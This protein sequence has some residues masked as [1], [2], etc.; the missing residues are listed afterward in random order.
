MVDIHA[1]SALERFKI[2][3]SRHLKNPRYDGLSSDPPVRFKSRSN[4]VFESG[5]DADRARKRGFDCSGEFFEFLGFSREEIFFEIIGKACIE[6][7]LYSEFFGSFSIEISFFEEIFLLPFFSSASE[8]HANF[9][10]V[11]V[12]KNFLCDECCPHFFDL[13]REEGDFFF[14]EEQ[15]AFAFRIEFFVGVVFIFGDVE[16]DDD[17]SPVVDRDVGSLEVCLA[18]TEALDL[19]TEQ[20]YTGIVLFDDLV[21][22]EGFFV[23]DDGDVRGLFHGDSIHKKEKSL[24]LCRFC[25]IR[26]S[27]EDF[28]ECLECAFSLDKI[29]RS[30]NGNDV[31]LREQLTDEGNFFCT[32]DVVEF[33]SKKIEINV[34]NAVFRQE[35]IPIF[36]DLVFVFDAD[37]V[38]DEP[39]LDCGNDIVADIA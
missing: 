17:R 5:F 37:H 39:T 23:R 27:F 38:I 34:E 12:E 7:G 8:C 32:V 4:D 2:L 18:G 19:G 36:V 15:Y 14:C 3:C 25:G 22:E 13:L 30:R 28:S 20:Y 29:R 31:D 1:E 16:T 26:E 6:H 10:K 11:S 9:E 33:L 35:N 21:V 24:I